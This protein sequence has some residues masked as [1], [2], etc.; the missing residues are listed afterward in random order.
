[1]DQDPSARICQQGIIY[2]D[3]LPIYHLV[4]DFAIISL[5]LMCAHSTAMFALCFFGMC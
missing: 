2:N 3:S 4:E 5:A 1:M